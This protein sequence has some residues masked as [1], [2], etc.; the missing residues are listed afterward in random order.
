MNTELATTQ[1]T[2][3]NFLQGDKIKTKFEELLGKRA[4]SFLTSV[5][6]VINSSDILK[7]ATKE[8]VYTSALMAATLDLPIN[9]NLGF[10]Y[11]VPFNN[12]KKG[13]QEAQFQI[14]YKGYIQLAQ[15]SGQ[16]KTIAATPIYEGQLLSSNPLEGFEFDFERKSSDTVIGYAGKFKLL[17][18]FEKTLYMTKEDLEKHGK[19]YSQTF[20]KGFG[21]WKDNFEAM[22][23]KTVLKLLLSKYAPLSIDMQRA[24]ISDSSVIR[25][26][27]FDNV[28]NIEVEYVDTETLSTEQK[29]VEDYE[30]EIKQHI[31][32]ADSLDKLKEVDDVVD[33]HGL[34]DLYEEKLQLLTPAK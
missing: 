5:L 10:A 29:Q 12:R 21:L 31:E 26:D 13:T 1:S 15:R 18:G 14:G 6:T 11:I 27:D 32:S 28:E 9:A 2:L 7:N 23:T 30:N 17:N 24:I 33:K 22:A 34:R 3:T 20:K 8:S 25:S 4:S 16:F 19:Q